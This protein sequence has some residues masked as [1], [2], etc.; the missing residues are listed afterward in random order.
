[1]TDSGEPKRPVGYGRGA[2]GKFLPGNRAASGNPRNAKAQRLRSVLIE[3]LT[4]AKMRAVSDALIR[5]AESGDLQAI[6]ELLNRICG[7]PAE[8][9][10]I[11][12]LEAI[13]TKLGIER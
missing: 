6:R 5:E 4:V 8:S 10:T 2:D 13:E 1:M 3:R 11:E 9:E 12:R 7:R